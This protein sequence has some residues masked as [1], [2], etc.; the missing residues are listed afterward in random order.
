MLDIKDLT[1]KI[2]CDDCMNILKQLPDKSVDLILTDPPYPDYHTELY[3][4]K[5]GMIDFLKQFSCKQL[6]FWSTKI[7]FPLDYFAIH[8]WDKLVG[9]ASEYERIFERNS[10]NRQ[11]RMFRA[12]VMNSTVAASFG[13]DIFYGHPSQ[14]PIKLIK[15]LVEEYSNLGDLILDPFCGSGT[16]CVAAKLLGRNYIGIDISQAYVDIAR[17]RLRDTEESLFKAVSRCPA[18]ITQPLDGR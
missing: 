13:G 14:K 15:K 12:Y 10:T 17:N 4:Y 6:I 8:I 11:W 16:T 9:C 2:I 7:D 1:N 3:G 5:E 18:N